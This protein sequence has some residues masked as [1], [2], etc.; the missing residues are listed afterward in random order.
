MK[1]FEYIIKHY[2]V[3]DKLSDH[4]NE[5]GREGWEVVMVDRKLLPD[6]TNGNKWFE[7]VIYKREINEKI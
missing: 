3:A 4:L 1:K 7:E 5:M 6:M 2:P